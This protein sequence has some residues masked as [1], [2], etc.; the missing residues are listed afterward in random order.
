[1]NKNKFLRFSL[2]FALTLF[3]FMAVTTH[4][5][6]PGS[7]VTVD[8]KQL[9]GVLRWKAVA[10][11]YVITIAVGG[12]TKQQIETELAPEQIAKMQIA[13]PKDLDNA[14]RAV[15]S[16]KGESVIGALDKIAQ[17]Y[18]M[19]Q[20]DEQA[21]RWLVEAYMQKGDANSAIK[22]AER[23][24]ALRPETGYK[25]EMAVT[26][27]QALLKGDRA[28]KLEGLLDDAIK[29]GS[30]EATAYALI[31]RGDLILKRGE[32]NDN[33]ENALIN[34][35]LRV[36]TLFRNVKAAQPEALYKTAKCLEKLGQTARAGEQMDLLR[37]D[38]A[39]SEWARKP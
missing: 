8:G 34:G 4:G 12:A 31:L 18:S 22:A 33:L 39:D 2:G 32:S 36:I 37:K 26:Y 3:T 6:V 9:T 38:F 28:S 21:T 10:R 24:V 13:K 29:S 30:R 1:M 27:W 25:G 19:L 14:I 17:E 20:W 15:Q 7:P 11:K 35:Y 16:G 5:D 23:T